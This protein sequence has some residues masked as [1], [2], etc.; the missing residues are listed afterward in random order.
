MMLTISWQLTLVALIML[1][2]SGGFIAVIIKH[3]QKFLKQQQ[4][5]LGHINGQIEEV[6][7][8]NNIVKAFNKEE[9]LIDEFEKT[10]KTLYNLKALAK[11]N[12]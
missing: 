9:S 5:Y 6:F 3:S 11:G 7:S 10:S 2:L 4:E 1:P 8:G 12:P